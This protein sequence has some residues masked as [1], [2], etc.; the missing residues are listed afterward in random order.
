VTETGR[1]TILV[2]APREPDS[3]NWQCDILEA[4]CASWFDDY[5]LVRLYEEHPRAEALR[6]PPINKLYAVR[7]WAESH[8]TARAGRVLVC[9]P[10]VVFRSPLT[11]E[12]EQGWLVSDEFYPGAPPGGPF[13]PDRVAQIREALGLTFSTARYVQAHTG[14]MV[15]HGEDLPGVAAL[16][17]QLAE[18]LRPLM[19]RSH[20]A[21]QTEM[22]A[23][24]LA[25]AE[26]GLRVRLAPLAACNDWEVRAED[27]AALHYCQPILSSGREVWYKHRPNAL[28]DLCRLDLTALDRAIDVQLVK[29]IRGLTRRINHGTPPPAL[30]K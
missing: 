6:C 26:I 2:S 12:A 27:F 16:A 21:W 30:S 8:P 3:L 20:H 18:R 15:F 9:D 28:E 13:S 11:V 23:W 7:R 25:A 29:T 14:V 24:Y 22:Y 1:T 17:E 10:D 4:S 19:T 5:T